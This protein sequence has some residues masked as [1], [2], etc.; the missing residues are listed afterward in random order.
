MSTLLQPLISYA[1]GSVGA[2]VF[3]RNQHGP[4]TRAR[5]APTGGPTVLQLA[6][7]RAWSRTIFRW[8][9]ILTP[10]Q[11][12]A[13]N[14]YA[15]QLIQWSP[16]NRRTVLSGQQLFMRVNLPRA[17]SP[18]GWS[19][20]PP[21]RFEE[22]AWTTPFDTYSGGLGFVF[23]S[24]NQADEWANT[25]FAGMHVSVSDA[26]PSSINFYKTPFRRA[27]LIRGYAAGPP[28]TTQF[29]IDPWGI[30]PLPRRWL[31]SY[32]LLGD[33]RVASPRILPLDDN[34]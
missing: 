19:L 9:S 15:A 13:W 21:T 34:V 7:Q 32:V 16:S 8:V 1:S 2:T 22:T 27:K 26:R 11:H 23:F 14:D 29:A 28:A 24:I 33:G 30:N 17:G 20:D 5:T 31:R 10:A 3:A 25:D 12:K 4:Y 6:S 18:L